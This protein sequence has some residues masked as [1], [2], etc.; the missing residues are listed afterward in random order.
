MSTIYS[1]AK[2]LRKPV[3]SYLISSCSAHIRY[4]WTAIQFQRT[5]R[6]WWLLIN[7]YANYVRHTPPHY[8]ASLPRNLF[9]FKMFTL[10]FGLAGSK[11]NCG[12][13]SV[14]R[15]GPVRRHC[16]TSSANGFVY[17]Y[18][19][20]KFIRLLRQC[21]VFSFTLYS[22]TISFAVVFVVVVAFLLFFT[23]F[24]LACFI[25]WPFSYLSCASAANTV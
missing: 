3:L 5:Q 4:S 21:S 23:K 1:I 22:V 24:L 7:F 12:W 10:D 11:S 14:T 16:L 19:K 20:R 17:F 25:L 8:G 18:L 15:E 2:L 9:S 13:V 6:W